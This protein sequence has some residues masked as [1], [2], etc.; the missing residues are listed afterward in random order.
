MDVIE[1]RVSLFILALPTPDGV[2]T[3]AVEAVIEFIFIRFVEVAILAI[4]PIP[5]PDCLPWVLVAYT[6]VDI[7]AVFAIAP[8]VDFV[9]FGGHHRHHFRVIITI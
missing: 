6:P 7:W 9:E 2:F 4:G 1:L 5:A 3:V 8:E